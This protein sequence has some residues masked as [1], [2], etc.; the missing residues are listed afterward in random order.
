MKE[1]VPKATDTR[2]GCKTL[3]GRTC[4]GG[5]HDVS[6]RMN[7]HFGEMI[8]QCDRCKTRYSVPVDEDKDIF[9]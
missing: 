6:S 7:L 1:F 2:C 5:L 3:S 9:E 8:L 4:G